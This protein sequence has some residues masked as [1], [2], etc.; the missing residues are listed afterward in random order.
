MTVY[1]F[2]NYPVP[3]VCKSVSFLSE[4][5][6]IYPTLQSTLYRILFSDY[7]SKIQPAGPKVVYYLYTMYYFHQ[8]HVTH[9]IITENIRTPDIKMFAILD[10]SVSHFTQSCCVE[11][12]GEGAK[13]STHFGF[14]FGSKLAT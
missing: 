2:S 1:N 4:E 13:I 5:T 6:Q 12:T 9:H 14:G 3:N 7:S 11:T 8:T 10:I